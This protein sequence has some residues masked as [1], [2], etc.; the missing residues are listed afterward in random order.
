[1]QRQAPASQAWERKYPE[2][3]VMVTTVSAEG[4]PNIITLGWAMPTSGQP[5]M[6]AIS[7]GLTR[8]SLEAIR[9]AGEFVLSFPSDAMAEDTLFFGTKSGRDT[10]KLAERKTATR[11]ATRID[12]VLLSEAVANFRSGP[13]TQ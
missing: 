5:P 8:Y 9:K 1:M 10:D 12:C 2:H 3:I 13:Q 7:V 4:K 11:P 6:M